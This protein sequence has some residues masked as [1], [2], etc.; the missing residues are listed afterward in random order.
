[1]GSRLAVSLLALCMACST[2]AP[3]PHWGD[4]VTGDDAAAGDGDVPGDPAGDAGG[5]PAPGDPSPGDPNAPL[6]LTVVTFNTGTSTGLLHDLDTS[7]GYTSDEAEI[8]EDWYGNGLAWRAAIDGATTFFAALQPDLVAFQEIFH[9]EECA[10]IPSQYH[11]GFICEVWSPGDPTVAQMVLG[12]GYQIAC[13]WQKTDKCAAVKKS[14]GSFAGCDRDLCLDGLDGFRV[15]TCGGGSR[16]G[17][18]VVELVAGGQLT[19]VTHHGSSGVEFAD[20]MCRVR[21]IDQI[22]LDFGD[23][24]PAANGVRN[25]VMGDL[26]TDPGRWTLFDPSAV[27]WNDFVGGGHDFDWITDASNDATPT[28]NGIV[29]IDHVA[30]D[31]FTGSCVHPGVDGEPPVLDFI[32]FDHLPAVCTLTER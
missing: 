22:F 15:D 32:L 23:G 16:N 7:D 14:F 30:S 3:G 11:D 20:Q 13:N 29:N 27:R 10:T 25:I 12:D 18:G 4:D 9:P 1:M 28:Y 2:S 6:N 26:N 5:D 19:L 21:Q 8:A 24:D 31:S 17:R